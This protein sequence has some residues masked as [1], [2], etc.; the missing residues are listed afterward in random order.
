[1]AALY[2]LT[3]SSFSHFFFSSCFV[4]FSPRPSLPF[5]SLCLH[6]SI[7]LLSPQPV[8]SEVEQAVSQEMPGG[9]Q[10]AG[11]LLAGHLPG[12]P[13]HSNHRFRASPAASVVN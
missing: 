8:L 12:F 6:P 9:S 11:F 10:I 13:Q 5:S 4:F 3:H 7:S 2:T 1:M